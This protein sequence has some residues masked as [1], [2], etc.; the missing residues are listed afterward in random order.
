MCLQHS[1][2]LYDRPYT[3]NG[4]DVRVLMC[5]PCKCWGIFYESYATK[6]SLHWYFHSAICVKHVDRR[7]LTSWTLAS[8]KSTLVTWARHKAHGW[9]SGKWRQA[10]L[11]LKH[12]SI[13]T[14]ILFTR[15]SRTL[16]WGCTALSIYIFAT[17]CS[18][19]SSVECPSELLT[20]SLEVVPMLLCGFTWL[21]KPHRQWPHSV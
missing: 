3:V 11:V 4:A 13:P 2:S 21:T 8:F 1:F 9:C 20:M 6:C 7:S 18:F 12:S 19:T 14:C 10:G 5:V 15:S 17:Y 16:W